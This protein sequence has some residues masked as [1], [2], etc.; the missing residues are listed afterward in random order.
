MNLRHAEVTEREMPAGFE[1]ARASVREALGGELMGCSVYEVPAGKR[2]WPYHY[3]L[4]NEEWLIVVSGKPTLRTPDGERELA[5][6]DVVAFVEGEAGAHTL[7]NA[8]DD[9]RTRGDL[10]DAQPRQRDLSRQRQGRR[11]L[12]VLQARRRRRLLGRRRGRS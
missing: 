9:P 10:L 8:T 4:G 3:E 1:H 11:E 6:G 2:L 5:E 7:T 12:L